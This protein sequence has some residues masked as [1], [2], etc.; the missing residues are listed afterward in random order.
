MAFDAAR[1]TNC[2]WLVDVLRADIGDS[3][4]PPLPTT[5][6][7][8]PSSLASP[9]SPVGPLP[10]DS[11]APSVDFTHF[12]SSGVTIVHGHEV[13]LHDSF[14]GQ[15]NNDDANQTSTNGTAVGVYG[16]D[17]AVHDCVIFGATGVG[18][19][20]EGASNSYS[21]LHIYGVEP[22]GGGGWVPGVAGGRPVRRTIIAGIWVAFFSESASN[23]RAGRRTPRAS[24]SSSPSS[25][26]TRKL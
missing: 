11:T 7:L 23:H 1:R 24:P 22:A 16:N 4:A 19:V 20:N 21:G 25:R 2:L 3:C 14:I 17:H 13:I 6:L 26:T 15:Y 5:P 12:V 9:P 18:I 8:Y 10:S